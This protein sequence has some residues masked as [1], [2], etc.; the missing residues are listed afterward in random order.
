MRFAHSW[1]TVISADSVRVRFGSIHSL[2]RTE[3]RLAR[4]RAPAIAFQIIFCFA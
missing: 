3:H 4:R 2:L 1:T